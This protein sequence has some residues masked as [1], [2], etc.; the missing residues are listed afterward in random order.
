MPPDYAFPFQWEVI[1]VLRRALEANPRDARAPYYLGNL[2]FDSQPEEAVR[3]WEK[4]A[5]I[6]PSFSIVHRNLAI[7]YAH[8]KPT[9]DGARAIA[10]LEKAV[11]LPDKYARHFEE[12][13]ELYAKAGKPPEQRLAL[14]EQS[15]AIVA[16]RDDALSREI[17]LKVFVGKYDEA[18]QLMTGRVFSVWEGGTLA[19][20][21][22]WVDA[23]LLRGERELATGKAAAALADF[24]AAGDIPDNLPSDAGAAGGHEAQ[25]AYWTGLA[26]EAMGG[27][28]QSQAMLAASGVSFEGRARSRG[29]RRPIQL[30]SL[31]R[32]LLC[33]AG[34]TKTRPERASGRRAQESVGGRQGGFGTGSDHRPAGAE[35]EESPQ[36]RACVQSLSGGACSIW[37]WARTRR[38]RNNSAPHSPPVPISWEPKP[39]W[40]GYADIWFHHRLPS[41]ALTFMIFSALIASLRFLCARPD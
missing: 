6:D 7:A 36:C 25:L 41:A 11:A 19:V 9:N 14:L 4:S 18:I 28:R 21:E 40:T 22:H 10:E 31:G 32:A 39:L 3:L 37:G 16:K 1:P 5:A 29:F 8:Q 30:Q 13:D 33:G 35:G 15:Q 12:L 27:R 20:A 24:Q 23:H 2:L 38:P 26:H 34:P 17:G